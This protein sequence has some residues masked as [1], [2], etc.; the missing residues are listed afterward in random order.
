[1]RF[2]D[3]TFA[4]WSR[5]DVNALDALSFDAS[6]G[7]KLAIVGPIGAGKSTVFQL[8]LRFYDPQRGRIYFDGCDIRT[9]DPADLRSRIGVVSQQPAIF[10]SDVWENIRFGRP[11][12]SN[13][14]VRNAAKSIGA[15]EF[16]EQLPQG[17]AT[18]LGKEACAC[19]AGSAS[20]LRSRGRYCEIQRCFCWMR[21][22]CLDAEND[23]H[24]KEALARVTADR[25]TLIIAHRLATVRD[26]NRIIVLN[27]GRKVAEG[28]HPSLIE[29]CE[30]YKRLT[31]LE[32]DEAS[33]ARS[34]LTFIPAKPFG[35]GKGIDAKSSVEDANLISGIQIRRELRVT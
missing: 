16:L 2:E 8:L 14:E 29:S 3:V 4:F 27:E 30:I 22:P 10:A 13:K 28:A 17:F 1:M 9:V 6:P 5:P 26:C 31:S 33:A 32:F 34:Q 21:Q 23:Q 7:E 35:N 11:S 20:L 19:R 15:L 12:A 18:Y 25:T 24:V